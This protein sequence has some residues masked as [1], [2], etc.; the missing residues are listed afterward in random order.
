MVRG[1][2][3]GREVQDSLLGRRWRGRLVVAG[4]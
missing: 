2:A 3:G 4:G 1:M